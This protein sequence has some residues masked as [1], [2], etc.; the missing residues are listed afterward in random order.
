MSKLFIGWVQ[1]VRFFASAPIANGGSGLAWHTDDATLRHGFEIFGEVQEAVVVKDRDT[2]R[3]RGFGLVRF[4]HERDAVVAQQAMNNKEISI[5]ADKISLP[6]RFDGRVI[7]VGPASDRQDRSGGEAFHGRGGYN[8]SEIGVDGRS[9]GG[10]YGGYVR[11]VRLGN[12]SISSTTPSSDEPVSPWADLSAVQE[13]AGLLDHRY[14]PM[15]GVGRGGSSRVS[16]EESASGPAAPDIG[17]LREVITFDWELPS[18]LREISSSA[19]AYAR[20]ESVLDAITLVAKSDS[21]ELMTCRQYLEGSHPDMGVKLVGICI[22]ALGSPGYVSGKEDPQFKDIAVWLCLTFRTPRNGVTVMVSTGSFNGS[23]FTMS[24]THMLSSP[25]CWSQLFEN[26]VVVV[27]PAEVF[28]T[29][30]LLKLSFGALLQL[31]AVEYPVEIESGL[32][33][34][35]YSTALVPVDINDRG[36]LRKSELLATQGSWLQ[37]QTL[38]ELHTAEALLGWCASAQ[39]RLGTDSL[40]ANVGWSDAKVKPT[41]WRWKGANLQLLAQSAAPIQI[42]AQVG[43][44]WERAVNTVR[45][46]PGG[47]YT[48]CLASSMLE[49]AILYDV[50]AQRAWLVPLLSIYHHML[51]VYHSMMSPPGDR[52]P[53]PVAI[54]S[55]GSASSL[56]SLRANGAVA[57]E[58]VGEDTLTVRELI[59]GFSINFSMTTLQPP[60]GSRIYGYE[61]M[62][63][64]VGSPR[65]DLKTIM[66]ERPGLGWAPLLNELPCLFCAGLGDAIVGTR[67]SKLDSPCNYLPVGR[68]LLA[69]PVET[70]QT[71]CRKQGS[72][73]T[74]E[75]RRITRDY[76]LALSGQPFIR[77]VHGAGTSSCWD[78]PEEFIQKIQRGADADSGEQARGETGP[79]TRGAVVLGSVGGQG[80][81]RAYELW[82]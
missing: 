50:S 42:G 1:I 60:R 28:P 7:R 76:V 19:N 16:V 57:V 56:E 58:G 30:G 29:N 26:A 31:A 40:E 37:R 81:R 63:L 67:A 12:S 20:R 21:V 10:G 27:M 34:M 51:L 59:M 15:L 25:A 43:F 48:R 9:Y 24:E 3:S 8:R 11:A 72:T 44:A 33:L 52:R 65:S 69:S 6:I 73:L 62:D 32:V 35:G 55:N 53:I 39:V 13:N 4:A 23:R 17:R 38:E 71:L 74:N 45:F 41:T 70:I 64:V 49:Q 80:F 36:Q 79:P 54:P 61:F 47:N 77:C 68:N 2:L 66:V 75:H 46:T 14:L 78:H 82:R 5:V 22:D 18:L